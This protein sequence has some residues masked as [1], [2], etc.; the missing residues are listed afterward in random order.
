VNDDDRAQIIHGFVRHG[1][2]WVRIERKIELE[3]AR[4]KRIEDGY[5]FFQSEWIPI[6]EK[7][8]RTRMCVS[9]P[10][11]ATPRQVTINRQVYNV[12]NRTYNA[13]FDQGRHLHVDPR[14][15]P[16]NAAAPESRA[17]GS[18]EDS[19]AGPSLPP[20]APEGWDRRRLPDRRSSAG[21]QPPSGDPPPP[22]ARRNESGD[23]F[24][25]D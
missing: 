21:R 4:R 10:A 1:D 25:F 22:S 18:L 11:E 16:P 8:A 14:H 3:A 2:R 7:I 9:Q 15:M 17:G 12:D 19:Q 23:P 20:H 24:D 13:T 5:V 6:D